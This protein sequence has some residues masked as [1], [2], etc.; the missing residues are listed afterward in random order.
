M[1]EEKIVRNAVEAEDAAVT[2]ALRSLPRVDAPL[3]FEAGVRARLAEGV[4]RR[5]WFLSPAISLPVAAAVVIGVIVAMWSG[6]GPREIAETVP[7]VTEA[8]SD[9][10]IG[11]VKTTNAMDGDASAP[12]AGSNARKP[13]E[14]RVVERGADAA[15]VGDGPSLQSEGPVRTAPST[16]AVNF[17]SALGAG[18]A[19]SGDALRVSYVSPGSSAER[20]GLRSGDQVIAVDGINLKGNISLPEGFSGMFLQVSRPGED[21]PLLLRVR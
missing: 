13:D 5:P 14:Y 1:S 21:K 3:G 12:S 7:P 18:V 19:V 17:L 2:A 15:A 8:G 6:N 16:N 11:S 20:T 10:A 4:R 9:A